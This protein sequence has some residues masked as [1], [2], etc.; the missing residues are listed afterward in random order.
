MIKLK[1]KILV[2]NP[3]YA[4][5]RESFIV[6]FTELNKHLSSWALPV[7]EDVG[8]AF[9]F[10]QTGKWRKTRQL[11]PSTG[12]GGSAS[13]ASAAPFTQPCRSGLGS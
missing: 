11:V 3:Y 1:R 2:Q 8:N 6:G 10:L 4:E 7:L 5:I 9:S 13:L 12:R